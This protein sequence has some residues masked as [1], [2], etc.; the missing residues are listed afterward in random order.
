MNS[1]SRKRSSV[2]PTTA[3]QVDTVSRCGGA[4]SGGEPTCSRTFG[5]IVIQD[6]SD[7]EADKAT[8]L[9]H[10]LM[11][12]AAPNRDGAPVKAMISGAVGGI[13]GLLL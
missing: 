13:M 12:T 1:E 11:P 5:S 9:A 7:R 6:L 3:L 10:D 2:N 4:Q 8:G